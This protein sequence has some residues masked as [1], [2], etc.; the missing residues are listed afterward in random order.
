M[1]AGSTRRRTIP[2]IKLD[3]AE[4]QWAISQKRRALYEEEERLGE[5]AWLKG[6]FGLLY[7]VRALR[8]ELDNLYHKLDRLLLE[9][10]IA[11][12]ERDVERL[13]VQRTVRG[14]N[15][16]PFMGAHSNIGNLVHNNPDINT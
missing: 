1:L 14:G 10:D 8:R 11:Q 7:E 5:A 12:D 2:A 16:D 4:L 9:L 6:R 15:A 3:L 13:R